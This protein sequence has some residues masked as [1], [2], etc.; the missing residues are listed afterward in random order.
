MS[1][2][3]HTYD[4]LPYAAVPLK[5]AYEYEPVF[6]NLSSEQES[7]ILGVEAAL[8]TE[9][10]NTEEKLFFN[11]LPRLAATAEAG[12]TKKKEPYR[13]FTKRLPPHYALYERLGL[14]YAKH[15]EQ[16]LP[17]WKRIA[18]TITFFFQETDAELNAQ[19]RQT[20]LDATADNIIRK[21]QYE[22]K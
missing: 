5:A 13:A 11:A 20:L 7:N 17:L 2:Y 4:D 8:W 16:P 10:I 9:W 21:E 6:D 14:T 18:G 1:A 19:K 12:W 22:V 3:F 15:A